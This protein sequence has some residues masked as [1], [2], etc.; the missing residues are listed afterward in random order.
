MAASAEIR[1][2]AIYP[3]AHDSLG[4]THRILEC[5]SIDN[6]F[7]IEENEIGGISFA[8]QTALREPNRCAGIPVIL[9]TASASVISFSS[10]L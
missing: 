7:G 4:R 6:L 9:R 1:E 5:S 2:N 10:R 3:H 8:D